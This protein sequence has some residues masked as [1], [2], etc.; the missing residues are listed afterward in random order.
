M[1]AFLTVALASVILLLGFAF[2]V[3]GGVHRDMRAILDVLGA[4][5]AK[6]MRAAELEAA[7]GDTATSTAARIQLERDGMIA[8]VPDHEAVQAIERLAEIC[9]RH[10]FALDTTRRQLAEVHRWMSRGQGPVRRYVIT[11]RGRYERSRKP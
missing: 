9:E 5:D 6:P 11:D 3:V 4:P 7:I 10:G 1:I 8:R 2:W